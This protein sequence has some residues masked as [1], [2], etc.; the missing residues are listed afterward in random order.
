MEYAA[1]ELLEKTQAEQTAVNVAILKRLNIAREQL[2]KLLEQATED[3][4]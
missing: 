4:K 2:N 3:V 1:E